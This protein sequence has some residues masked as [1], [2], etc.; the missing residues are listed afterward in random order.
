LGIFF[1]L[2]KNKEDFLYRKSRIRQRWVK[3]SLSCIALGE[4]D[5]G[6][7]RIRRHA[8][9]IPDHHGRIVVIAV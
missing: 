1:Y 2:P 8:A 6:T 9:L 4:L 5:E 3:L 7:D